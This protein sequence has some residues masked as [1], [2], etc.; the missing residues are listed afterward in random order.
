VRRTIATLLVVVSP[1]LT[2]VPV[3]A[4]EVRVAAGPAGTP[5]A[6]NI[7]QTPIAPA[8]APAVASPAVAAPV[9]AVQVPAVAAPATHAVAR[10]AVKAVRAKAP[11]RA[12]LTDAAYAARLQAELCRAR[13]IFCGLDHGGRYPAR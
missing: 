3:G 2:A 8:P 6:P 12:A 7:V 11:S 5:A 9:A 1:L 4:S 10:P 13:Q